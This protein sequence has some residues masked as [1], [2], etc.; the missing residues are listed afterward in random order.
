MKTNVLYRA[1][2]KVIF[3]CYHIPYT[4]QSQRERENKT[5][6]K[7]QKMPKLLKYDF[8]QN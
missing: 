4:A 2:I 1:S 3:K 5:H 6:T 7:M 8:E